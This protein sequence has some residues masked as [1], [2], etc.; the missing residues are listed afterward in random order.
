MVATTTSG[1]LLRSAAPV[2]PAHR[3]LSARQRRIDRASG[4]ALEILS[5]AIE[6]L[7]DEY[8]YH[9]GQLTGSDGELHA[10]QILAML[11]REIYAAC[12]EVPTFNERC[13]AFVRRFWN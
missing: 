10:M 11:N 8:V 3:L 2:A 9:G 6:Y 12:P 7:A 5:H 13:T 1:F 4:R